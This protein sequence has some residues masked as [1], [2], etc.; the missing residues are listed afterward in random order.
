MIY[1]NTPTLT[2]KEIANIKEGKK[3]LEEIK[4]AYIFPFKSDGRTGEFGKGA[5]KSSYGS[6]V[7]WYC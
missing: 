4:R 2:I 3:T 6:G 5:Q 1:N 7:L